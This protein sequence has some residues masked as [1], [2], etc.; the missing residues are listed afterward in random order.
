MDWGL[1]LW[2]VWYLLLQALNRSAHMYHGLIRIL[3]NFS[4]THLFNLLSSDRQF[5][6]CW[7]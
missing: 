7:L 6:S 5:H 4:K 1:A 3:T 2:C